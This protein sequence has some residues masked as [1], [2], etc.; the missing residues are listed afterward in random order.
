MTG[1]TGTSL[2]TSG[3]RFLDSSNSLLETKLRITCLA[4]EIYLSQLWL[5][6]LALRCPRENF[7]QVS[8]PLTVAVALHVTG[9][10]VLRTHLW[11]LWLIHAIGPVMFGRSSCISGLLTDVCSFSFRQYRQ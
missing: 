4:Q 7:C 9:V 10:R 3:L 11:G 6:A 8:A 2:F 5:C 1:G